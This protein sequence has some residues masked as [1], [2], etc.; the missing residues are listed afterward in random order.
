MEFYIDCIKDDRFEFFVSGKRRDTRC[1]STGRASY[2]G[3]HRFS[4]FSDAYGI[5]HFKDIPSG[6]YEIYYHFPLKH[7]A[8]TDF[9]DIEVNDN[10]GTI[11][12][13][14]YD[15]KT[16]E[17]GTWQKIGEQ[18]ILMS[19]DP[20][21]L[22]VQKRAGTS[23]TFR[24][25]AIKLVQLAVISVPPRADHINVS[26]LLVP[27][28]T[29]SG[30]Y[31]YVNDINYD[32][33]G[34]IKKWY[35]S[36]KNDGAVSWTPVGT[37]DTYTLKK[38]DSNKYIKYEVTPKADVSVSEL[39]TG[40]SVSY[41][42]G[43][44]PN[45]VKKPVATNIKVEGSTIHYLTLSMTYEYNNINQYPE[46]DTT[47]QWYVGDNV[48]DV[49]SPI[50]GASGTVKQGEKISYTFHSDSIGKYFR[51]GITPRHAAAV[52]DETF[53]VVCGPVIE[54][55]AVQPEAIAPVIIGTGAA[56][57]K[58]AAGY[59][60]KH[61]FHL[62]EGNTRFQ[63]Y[64]SDTRNGTYKAISAATERS[65]ITND[66]QMG[67]YLKVAV[68]PV[69]KINGIEGVTKESEPILMKWKLAW[70][71][72]FDYKAVDGLDPAFTKNWVSANKSYH[73]KMEC[74]R[75]P[76]NVEVSDGTLKLKQFKENPPLEGQ[77]WS[78][79]SVHTKDTFGYGRYEASFKYAAAAGLNQS[80]WLMTP[81]EDIHQ[82][83][84][85][86]IDVN[87]GHYP[88]FIHTNLHWIDQDGKDRSSS[89]AYQ[90]PGVSDMSKDFHIFNFDWDENAIVL[91]ADG[92]EYRR[93]LNNVAKADTLK[94]NIY[95][96]EAILRWAGEP[97]DEIDGSVMEVDY[98]RYYQLFDESYIDKE[99]LYILIDKVEKLLKMKRTDKTNES[100]QQN[101]RLTALN[102]AIA[103]AKQIT[104]KPNTTQQQVNDSYRKLDSAWN[105]FNKK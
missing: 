103:H 48:M 69:V 39:Q 92:V 51:I 44:I 84:G 74:G 52:G 93:I 87:E 66:S 65:Y 16:I 76:K 38:Q 46:T 88:N 89:T 13:E 70:S 6:V 41:I 19:A 82:N 62:E 14:T 96:S 75:W 71:D 30:S 73:D 29:L 91:Y 35:H 31:Q 33:L 37:G 20:G 40:K 64:I 56:N 11:I 98:I 18:Y 78:S 72:E 63:W 60:Y 50:P 45:S 42:I 2:G 99:P 17:T 83:H 43:P 3:Y 7:D 12:N 68:T 9:A 36:D 59:Q 97:T 81:G 101:S 26:G 67:K 25:D 32:E 54:M 27:G 58:I 95:F 4:G 55:P 57:H 61:L 53:S 105:N 10:N 5:W 23:G 102:A 28:E 86:E 104:D 1:S 90:I 22:K 85:Y 24:M 80:F 100:D 34:T 8:N 49:T 77:K 79:G 15:M 94:A 21:Y 47:Y